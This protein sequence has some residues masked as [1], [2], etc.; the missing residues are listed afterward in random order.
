MAKSPFEIGMFLPVG[1][2]GM[3][4]GETSNYDSL[5]AMTQRAEALGY[6]FVGVLD[7]LLFHH[8]ECWTMLGALAEATK[9]IKLISYVTC[10][11]YRNPALLA[12]MTDTMDEISGGRI[13]LGVGAGDSETEHENFGFPTDRLVSRFEEAMEIIAPLVRKRSIERFEGT[14]YQ[15]HDIAFEPKGPTANGAP[16]LIG[17]LGGPRMM[18]LTARYADIWTA[19]FPATNGTLDGFVEASRRFTTACELE[20]RD[21]ESVTKMVE[22]VVRAPEGPPSMWWDGYTVEGTSESIAEELVQFREA[23]A[24]QIMIWIEPNNIEGIEALA[25]AVRIAK[26]A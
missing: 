20:G 26:S 11:G 9:S 6:D 18:R 25:D 22:V 23:G 10:T 17:S 24:D 14:Y 1:G 21:P 8:W 2:E 5:R 4:G 19:S 15:A 13:V 3:M 12:R 7:H 16:I